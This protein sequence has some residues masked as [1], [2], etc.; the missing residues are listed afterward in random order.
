MDASGSECAR[1]AYPFRGYQS[2]NFTS[3]LCGVTD[4]L[5]AVLVLSMIVFMAARAAPVIAARVE[6]QVQ[7]EVPLRLV[8][9]VLDMRTSIIATLAVLILGSGVVGERWI[10]HELFLVALVLTIGIVSI[11]RRYRFTASG[12]SPNRATFRAWSEFQAW[13]I[14]GN[15]I[16]L[17]GK[18][19]F[20][21]LKLYVAGADRDGVVQLV[22]RY[23]PR[24]AAQRPQGIDRRGRGAPKLART[25]GG[26][27]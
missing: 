11:P 6:G 9:R 19:R 14:S 8:F 20:S 17:T 16:T 10:S 4:L 7:L 22:G 2:S 13:Q 5:G 1:R 24:N 21:S 18:E 15:V 25:K 3:G 12:V 27:R 23:L 26:T